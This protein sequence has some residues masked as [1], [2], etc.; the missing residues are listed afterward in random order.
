MTK[1]GSLRSGHSQAATGTAFATARALAVIVILA[2]GSTACGNQNAPPPVAPEASHARDNDPPGWRRVVLTS[3]SDGRPAVSLSVPP[4][5][6]F[7]EHSGTHGMEGYV[8]APHFVIELDYGTFIGG[9]A[10]FLRPERG[11]ERVRED[12]TID[13]ASAQLVRVRRPIALPAG[14][15]RPT[16]ARE[17]P[18][19]LELAIDRAGPDRRGVFAAAGCDDA[20][21]CADAEKVLR[22][23]KL[24]ALHGAQVPSGKPPIPPP[25]VR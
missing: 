9:P 5:T 14:R 15:S 19:G 20:H 22:S 11:E 3:A 21:G 17:F 16:N 10:T 25:P 4:D 23:I 24:L 1:S 8:A 7:S 18:V 12:T 13:R 2:A 6:A